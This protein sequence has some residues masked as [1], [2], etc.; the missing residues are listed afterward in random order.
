LRQIGVKITEELANP[1]KE[2]QKPEEKK[3]EEQPEE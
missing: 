1:E 3:P 2:E